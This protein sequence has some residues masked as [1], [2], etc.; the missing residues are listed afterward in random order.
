MFSLIR[1]LVGKI[2]FLLESCQTLFV[3]R[4]TLEDE[5]AEQIP[6]LYFG[7]YFII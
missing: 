5:V 4:T 2:P 3:P 7:L 1:I 6:C